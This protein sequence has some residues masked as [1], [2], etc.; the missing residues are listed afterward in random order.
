RASGPGWTQRL[1]GV[2]ADGALA[3]THVYPAGM[4]LGGAADAEL[5]GS[6]LKPQRADSSDGNEKEATTLDRRVP[7]ADTDGAA[8]A[9]GHDSSDALCRGTNG[10]DET[11]AEVRGAA[12]DCV[13]YR[14]NLCVANNL[15]F[16]SLR[17]EEPVEQGPGVL[18]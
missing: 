14:L 4:D 2:D 5:F 8:R 7:G 13:G 18:Q 3:V 6:R 10:P 12:N 15:L 16:Q 1:V 17:L 11:V 9:G